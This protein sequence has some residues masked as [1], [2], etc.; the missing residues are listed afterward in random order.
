M[1][2]KNATYEELQSAYDEIH[3]FLND[4]MVGP[5]HDSLIAS[6]EELGDKLQEYH[7]QL[8]EKNSSTFKASLEELDELITSAKEGIKELKEV[9]NKI[10]KLAKV[11]HA[12]DKVVEQIGKI[13]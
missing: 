11:A 13:I 3:S 1:H 7:S 4:E 6:F 5:E 2:D 9:D 10:K 8:I 12:V